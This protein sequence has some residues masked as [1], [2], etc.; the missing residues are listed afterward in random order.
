MEIVK[1]Y[2]YQ[3]SEKTLEKDIDKFY[4]KMP[5]G[6]LTEIYS[7]KKKNDAKEEKEQTK[8]NIKLANKLINFCINHFNDYNPKLNI[9]FTIF[10]YSILSYYQLWKNLQQ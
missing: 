9:Q 2:A 6:E 8:N 4:K 7:N 3:L 10:L 5:M 1:A